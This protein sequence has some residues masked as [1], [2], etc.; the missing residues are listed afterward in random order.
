MNEYNY[1]I[2]FKLSKDIIA[3]TT[4]HVTFTHQMDHHR[5]THKDSNRAM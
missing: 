1:F 3:I 2:I 5:S 4:S